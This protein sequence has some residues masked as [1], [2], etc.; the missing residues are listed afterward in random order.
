MSQKRR[1]TV[2][3]NKKVCLRSTQLSSFFFLLIPIRIS[4][5]LSVAL[6]SEALAKK[7]VS[8]AVYGLRNDLEKAFLSYFGCPVVSTDDFILPVIEDGVSATSEHYNK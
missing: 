2:G 5:D 3:R 6:E 4:T 8:D 1:G 7:R